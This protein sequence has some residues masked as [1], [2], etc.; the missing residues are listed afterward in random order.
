GGGISANPIVTKNIQRQLQLIYS[1]D[2]M[3]NSFSQPEVVASR[4]LNYSG[5]VGAY[6]NF[7]KLINKGMQK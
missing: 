7:K 3:Y 1:Q 4:F 6:L 5:R 2:N